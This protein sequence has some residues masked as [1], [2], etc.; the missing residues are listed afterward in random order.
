MHEFWEEQLPFYVA[1]TLPYEQARWLE[2]HMQTCPRCRRTLDEWCWIGNGIKSVGKQWSH[3]LPTLSPAVRRA[4]AMPQNVIPL[5]PRVLPSPRSKLHQRKKGRWLYPAVAAVVMVACLLMVAGML[6]YSLTPGNATPVGPTPVGKIAL[7]SS[8]TPTR[9]PLVPLTNSPRP[10]TTTTVEPTIVFVPPPDM[11]SSA[12]SDGIGT[13]EIGC[14][15]MPLTEPILVRERPEIDSAIV[16]LL[17]VDER[18]S[19][20]LNNGL[21]WYEVFDVERRLTGWLLADVVRLSGECEMFER[22][23]STPVFE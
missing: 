2:K 13:I 10:L 15:A 21:G 1:G 8:V 23:N 19:V 4:T 17:D 5:P 22:P 9:E 3:R 12:G 7:L 18:L 14:F 6:L 11:R 20:S 16:E